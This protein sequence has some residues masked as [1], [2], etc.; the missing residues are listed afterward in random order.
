MPEGGF[1]ETK[2]S[3]PTSFAI[4]VM[5][6]GAVLTALAMSKM[7]FDIIPKKD[8]TKVVFIEPPKDPPPI[9]E[10]VDKKVEVRQKA[11][12]DQVKPVIKVD[13]PT[14][15]AIDKPTPYIPIFDPGPSGDS[16]QK[17][18][19]LPLPPKPEPVPEG[20][21][22][23]ARIDPRSRLQPEYPAS[24][25][26]SER[27]GN[28]TVRVVVG[29]DGRVKSVE[30]LS[31]TSDAFFRA[32]EQHALRHWRFKPATIDGKPVESRKTM[33]VRFQLDS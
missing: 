6:H 28:V 21:R 14:D 8:P 15:L 2:R 30:K 7:E 22:V 26:R 16:I 13:R 5:M 19:D 18:I 1:F 32:T 17:P 23:E 31:A 11:A 25:Q 10:P 29:E 9:P 12:I 33:N 20:V 4:V 24:E 3:S 27:E